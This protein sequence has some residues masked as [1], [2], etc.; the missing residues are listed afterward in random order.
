[1]SQESKFNEEVSIKNAPNLT[2]QVM[3]NIRC[4]RTRFIFEVRKEKRWQLPDHPGDFGNKSL[5]SFMYSTE[6]KSRILNT[7]TSRATSLKHP[8]PAVVPWN[9]EAWGS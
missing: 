5:L 9:P 2:N 3:V 1:M 4:D 7:Q 8:L 6:A